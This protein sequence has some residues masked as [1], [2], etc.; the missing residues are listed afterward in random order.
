MIRLL[1]TKYQK[2][3]G[4]FLYTIFC[5]G[6]MLPA[7]AMH[8]TDYG[9][10]YSHV[11]AS[12]SK[13]NR[14]AMIS[15]PASAEKPAVAKPAIA[16]IGA[17]QKNIALQ[18]NNV[19]KILLNNP[20]IGGPGQPEM[21]SFKAVAAGDMVNTFTGDFNYNIPL[22]DVGGYPINIFYNGGITP[23]QEA[24]WVGLGWN[25]NPGTVSRNMRGIP[26]DF[27]GEDKLEQIQNMRPN[28]TW[29]ASVG[30]DLEIVGIKNILGI[31]LGASLG[32]S[33]NN[34]LGPALDLGIKGGVN[35]H[36]AGKNASE[37]DATPNLSLGL[38]ANLSS[39]NGLT[40]SPST[41][42]TAS[43]SITDLNLS[44]GFGLSTSYN[45]R[46]GIKALQISEQASASNSSVENKVETHKD[47]GHSS[48]LLASSSISFARPSYIPSI[49][50][51]LRNTSV[52]GRFQLGGALFGIHINGEL[53]GYSSRSVVDKVVQ[54]KPMV[55]YMYYQNANN[56][57]NA[58][59]DFTRINDKE[60]TPHT[61]IISAPQYTYD[62]FSISGEG[63]GGNIRAYR[64]D[65]GYVRDNYT[66]STDSDQSFGG[67]VGIPGH[68]GAQY[69]AV[70]TPTT[71]GEWKNGNKLRNVTGFTAAQGFNENVY[72]RNPGETS[73][74]DEN[75]FTRIG[76]DS[77][78]RFRLGGTGKNPTI[79]PVLEKFT[80]AG[81]QSG[82]VN[83]AQPGVNVNR[84]KR[85][86]IISFL[87]ALEASQAGLDKVIENYNSGPI[88]F[89]NHNDLIFQPVQ[90]VGDYR[91]AHHISQV[92]IT[93]ADGSR[94][95]YGIPVYNTMQRDFSFS[96]ADTDPNATGLVS[97][98]S[99]EMSNSSQHLN[100]NSN[101][102]GYLN[103][104]ATP[105]Y[106]H[107]FLLSGLL[108]SD[109][110]DVTGN[111][112]SDDDMG[113][114]VKFNYSKIDGLSKWRTPLTRQGTG[115]MANF[116][117]GSRS[118]S[119]DDKGIV[120]YGERESWYMQSVESK[121]MIA[122]FR[123]GD[124][125]DGKGAT[126]EFGDANPGD[127][128]HKKLDRI[129][130][131][132]KADLKKNGIN[133]AKP[134]KSV[135]FKY[136]YRLCPGTPDNTTTAP[137][138]STGKLTLDN[139]YFTF[140][141]QNR[142]QKNQYVFSYGSAANNPAYAFNS[143][144]RWGNYKNKTGNPASLNNMDYPYSEQVKTTA[145]NNAG[146]WSLKTILLPSGGQISVDYESDDYAFVQ[147]KRAS[148]MMNIKGFGRAAT[149]QP[150]SNLYESS[151][152]GIIENNFV[153]VNVAVPCTTSQQVFK[154]YIEGQTQLAFKLM[155]KMPNGGYEYL[156]SYATVADWGTTANPNT[157][158]IKINNVNNISPLSLT[159]AEYLRQQLPGQA[160]T[161]YD[162]SDNSGLETVAN[163]LL[164]MLN[165]LKNAFKDPLKEIRS[166]NYAKLTD[167][168]KC[169]VRLN[170]PDGYKYGGGIRV[171][172][173]RL[174]D[175]WQPMTG[176]YTSEYGQEYDYTTTE[177][178][179]GAERTI[180]SGVASYEP[181]IG[182]EENPFQTIVQVSDKLPMG[183]ASYGAV[184]M[185]L[186][187]AFFPS[188]LVGYS[189][190]TV[191]SITKNL[192]AGMKARS[193][194]GRQ[195]TEYY[196]AK[197]F[198][199]YY[200]YTPIDPGTDKQAHSAS[201]TAMFYKSA[202]DG[203]A[204]S[205]GFL[206][207]TNDM[208]G[209]L[210]SQ[211]SYP[212]SS[213]T[214]VN[215]TQNFYRNTGS[216]GFND[217]F[218]FADGAKGGAVNAG[219]MGID[220]ELMTDVREFSVKSTS[221]E[222]QGQ[223]DWFPVFGLPIWLPFFWPVSGHS[224]NVYRAVTA[225]KVVNYHGILDSV[226]VIDKGS[227]VSTRNLVY[228]AETGNVVVNRTNNEFNEPVY[229]LNYP[230]YW[231]YSGMG[232]AYKNIDA[233][234]TANFNNGAI[235]IST[236]GFESG[237]ELYIMK[238]GTDVPGGCRNSGNT[239][240]LWAYDST[241]NTTSLA[242]TDHHF[243]F[244]DA[245]GKPYTRNNV[246]FRIIRS[247]KRNM[248]GAQ[249]AG[250]SLMSDPV[251]GTAGNRKLRIDMNSKV[252]NSSAAEYK[253]KWQVDEGIIG[254]AVVNLC[255]GTVSTS[256]CTDPGPE[257]SINPYRK[258]LLGNY[259]PLRNMAFYGGR[260]E[261]DPLSSTPRKGFLSDFKAYWDFNGSNQLLPDETN[262][263][264]V[265]TSRLQK[266]NAKGMELETKDA[267]GIYTSS[268]YGFNKTMPVTVAN[269]SRYNEM[270]NEGFEDTK[271]MQLPGNHGNL[272]LINQCGIAGMDKLPSIYEVVVNTDTLP[273][274][275]HTGNYAI[276]LGN[277]K[278][279]A[280][281]WYNIVQDQ[282]AENFNMELKY[283]QEKVLNGFGGNVDSSRIYIDDNVGVMNMHQDPNNQFRWNGNFGNVLFSGSSAKYDHSYLWAYTGTDYDHPTGFNHNCT[284][285][286]SQFVQITQEV[287][288]YVH[289]FADINNPS[290]GT[291]TVHESADMQLNIYDREGNLMNTTYAM[292]GFTGQGTPYNN[293]FVQMNPITLCP[294]IYRLEWI[295]D[296]TI[297]ANCSANP[298][299]CQSIPVG[300]KFWYSLEKQ[301]TT[302][303]PYNDINPNV[304]IVAATPSFKNLSTVNGCTFLKPI[305][306][307][308][309][310]TT[311]TVAIPA[312]KKM[313]LSAW[314]KEDCGSVNGQVPCRDTTYKNNKID[315]FFYD[316]NIPVSSVGT[317]VE[318]VPTGNIIEGWQRY[319]GEF[320]APQGASFMKVE[321]AN[322]MQDPYAS[323]V[324]FDDI[325]IHP[326]NANM[327][328]YIYDPINLRL[329][330]ELDANNYA[331]FYEYDEEG[332]LIRTKAETKE[333]VKTIKESRS[334]KQKL[335]N[336]IQ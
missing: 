41:S 299:N 245:D 313:L 173:V 224:E 334:A 317:V 140:N 50:M 85:T 176:Q 336:T 86:Q 37:K 116:N 250:A 134:V 156:T 290:T 222:I 261:A 243:I 15:R 82:I 130:L 321:F 231:A 101:K 40:V 174:K 230:A 21:S 288:F 333:G 103:I 6:S 220:A 282:P 62:V 42:I 68:V 97:T 170:D 269:N 26:D 105:A 64:N 35:F 326:F 270:F 259:R 204:M 34:Q 110:V 287:P 145:D 263:Q 14:A 184:E 219:N 247:G 256:S 137:A 49:R 115:T 163:M 293:H 44:A 308:D 24:S 124:R 22:M 133:G 99:Q 120:S 75:Q 214:P 149:D 143:S 202:F 109:Y 13:G 139:I 198:P 56:N 268:K 150:G 60:V 181:G 169:F 136:S 329:V 121:T 217:K 112:I 79:E 309:S 322:T 273:F 279:V 332:T 236:A 71:I 108:S 114:A 18:S 118:D 67:D 212:D 128:T 3:I 283:D 126:D 77:L 248:L 104:A 292:G 78:V 164:G 234:Q 36:I 96:V 203:R 146:A 200:S 125:K 221:F 63:T 280:S 135:F 244:M 274:P 11:G 194:I 45:S 159:C 186:L 193:G 257:K 175:N 2:P 46:T 29:G 281:E 210:K 320:T 80:I 23:E 27:N 271:Y 300:S 241:R 129:D 258:G 17:L 182:G 102:N 188:P 316:N 318:L 216:K 113:N 74:L 267:L 111:G 31:N 65:M 285:G 30:A 165:S 66:G 107:S 48:S 10:Y 98:N 16:V 296:H 209:K 305:P 122:I 328:S 306:G 303:N 218:D 43:K 12:L 154:K 89:D 123:L 106:A 228:D 191:K 304:P 262:A 127:Y 61:P 323:K 9:N 73:V 294:G 148:V 266:T 325:R 233:V 183:P 238:Q 276:Q 5:A 54:S 249:L 229:S 1:A 297:T 76:G 160:F 171:K 94:Y 235:S 185:P 117:T 19:P 168:S 264:W 177:V 315:I 157:I 93:E 187:D 81:N 239:Y 331:T 195:V 55:G 152:S 278:P 144:D 38:A 100:A 211:A 265:W 51:P 153:F 208:H 59:M 53:E 286:T 167:A 190:V 335:I 166:H 57:D 151:G 88:L 225:T 28:N 215:Y 90:R 324:Y 52:A 58:V 314:V 289:L 20:D 330:S 119:K 312:D 199:M 227:Q 180:S 132:N 7:H 178:F 254:R 70:R 232:P 155:V 39:R 205:Q 226:I 260:T 301:N 246:Q 131:Y 284:I 87:T 69:T 298:Y 172:S 95:V 213:N 84:K 251:T 319:E 92:N 237:D 141:G 310:M 275:A 147:N 138:D 142:A 207:I 32:I 189:K 179:N 255:G 162:V 83:I 47:K 8:R 72:F 196:T 4:Y 201:L 158:W 291:P 192:P 311:A 161:G 272:Q 240:M 252:I 327:N 25:I 223:V 91:K 33:V 206:V 295:L 277:D 307:S 242:N 197:D 302:S 253:E